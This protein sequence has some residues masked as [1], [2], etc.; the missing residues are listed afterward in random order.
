M[1]KNTR[2]HMI[3]S[4]QSPWFDPTCVLNSWHVF[5]TIWPLRVC[6]T[7]LVFNPSFNLLPFSWVYFNPFFTNSRLCNSKFPNR[8]TVALIHQLRL[9][10][11]SKILVAGMYTN[12]N[13]QRKK[14]MRF[15]LYS[16]QIFM[17]FHLFNCNAR[18]PQ[19]HYFIWGF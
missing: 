7:Q 17:N 13:N 9:K 19:A 12:L 15:P 16:S 2:L 10:W 3:H 6:M 18:S 14:F 4:A 11:L 1:R 5:H 8:F